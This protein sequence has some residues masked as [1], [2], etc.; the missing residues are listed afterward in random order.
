MIKPTL[1]VVAGVVYCGDKILIARRAPGKHLAGLW[2]F[3]GGKIEPGETPEESLARELYEEFHLAVTVGNHIASQLHDYTDGSIHLH[4]YRAQ[5]EAACGPGNSHDD[6]A[7]I[8]P[9]DLQEFD[10]A[11][12][13]YFIRDILTADK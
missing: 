7:W 8:T 11:P 5:A 3:P 6:V 2:E 13:D 12:A 4:A 9:A 1:Q 10:L